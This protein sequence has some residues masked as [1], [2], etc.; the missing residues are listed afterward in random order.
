MGFYQKARNSA[1]FHLLQVDE[2]GVEEKDI[3][4]VCQQSN[5]SR[6]KAIKALRANDNDIVNAIMV[7]HCLFLPRSPMGTIFGGA[8]HFKIWYMS[9]D[10]S[11][12][13]LE[14]SY[15]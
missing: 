4:L 6:K 10:F 1:I 8:Y 13:F 11:M 9:S 5:V 15:E 12:R 7:S 14:I 2:T 3:E